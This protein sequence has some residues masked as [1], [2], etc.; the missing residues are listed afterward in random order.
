MYNVYYI[1]PNMTSNWNNE[2]VH[3]RWV[4][5]LGQNV[6]RLEDPAGISELIASTIGIAEGRVD[7]DDLAEDLQEVGAAREVAQ[8]IG[9]A[10]ARV[11]GKR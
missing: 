6:L 1:L 5:L 11:G 9:K 4:E 8:A 7:L 2:V 3:S 10:L